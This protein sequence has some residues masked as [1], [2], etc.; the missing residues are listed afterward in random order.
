[1]DDLS[2]KISSMLSDPQ[3]LAKIR[4]M[5]AGLLGNEQPSTP[6]PPPPPALPDID[7]GKLLGIMSKFKNNNTDNRSRLLLALKPHLSEK[8]QERVDR[9]VKILKLLDM[10]PLLQESGLMNIL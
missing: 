8:R 9:A 7:M 3:Q 4:E 1:M 10:L 5:A 6:P 2:E